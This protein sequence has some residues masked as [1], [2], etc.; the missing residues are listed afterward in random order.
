M[1]L[2]FLLFVAGAMAAP[3]LSPL[4]L[5]LL[6]QE[7]GGSLKITCIAPE[8]YTGSTFEL[9]AMGADVPAQSVSANP[10]QHK[11]DFTLDGTALASRCYR[12]RY[13]SYNGSAWQMSAFSMEIVPWVTPAVIPPLPPRPAILCRPPPLCGKIVPGFSQLPSA[14]PSWCCCCWQRQWWWPVESR[15]G[16]SGQRG[17]RRLAGRK[18]STPPPSF[19]MTTAPTPSA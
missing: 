11:V 9:F 10:G 5:G 8:S 14:W 1:R 12:C 3:R 15:P 13:R 2:E 6:F 19:P 4:P 17:S 18:C 16:D 7:D